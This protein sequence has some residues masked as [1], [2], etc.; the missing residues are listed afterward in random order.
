MLPCSHEEADSRMCLHV[1]DALE[2][3]ARKKFVRT[4]DTDVIVI[5]TDTFLS[6]KCI[7]IPAS[8]GQF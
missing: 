4:V 8:L 3:G 1:K 5:L 7:S 6:C 2:K